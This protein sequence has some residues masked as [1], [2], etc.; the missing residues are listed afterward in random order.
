[1]TQKQ[2]NQ[3]SVI[4]SGDTLILAGFREVK[5]ESGAMQLFNSQA[6]GGKG[7]KQQI[8]ETIV[9]ITPI[10]LHGFV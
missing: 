1:L 4:G 10:I 8:I 3:R 7:A 2:F 5:N 6:L 9:L